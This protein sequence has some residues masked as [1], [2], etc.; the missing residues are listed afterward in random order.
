[1]KDPRFTILYNGKDCTEELTQYGVSFDITDRLKDESDELSITFEDADRL[2]QSNWYPAKKDKI[3]V[4][5]GYSDEL[6]SFGVFEVDEIEHTGPPDILVIRA[7]A[8]GISKQLRTKRVVAHED[9]TLRQIA[10]AV[11]D[12]NGMEVVGDIRDIKLRRVTQVKETDLGFLRRLAEQ[13]GYV[14]SA[15][16]NKLVFTSVTEL[17]DSSPVTE[18]D[19]EDL[20]NFSIKNA[21]IGTK[22]K[23]VVVDWNEDEE[24]QVSAEMTIGEQ[25]TRFGADT[26]YADE[27][28]DNSVDAQV[29]SDDEYIFDAGVRGDDEALDVGSAALT[30]SNKYQVTC[31]GTTGGNPLLMAGSNI[32]LTGLYRVSGRFHL[33]RI[34]HSLSRGGGYTCTFDGGKIGDLADST[35]QQPRSKR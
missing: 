6:Y 21:S 26:A 24:Q 11:A 9:K 13:Y 8:A 14:F 12:Q 27:G 31:T 7:L 10:Q 30:A 2:F 1:M 18:L 19:R 3:E 32:D 16:D 22:S 35:K 17:F 28:E 20:S 34:T 4:Q 33:L 23:A 5:L 15:R 25:L 29:S